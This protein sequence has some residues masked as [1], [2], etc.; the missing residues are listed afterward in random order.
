MKKKLLAM[1]LILTLS[2]LTYVTA[3]AEGGTNPPPPPDNT[4]N[5]T[6]INITPFCDLPPY[7]I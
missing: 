4:T 3:F 5:T 2:L 1:T 7:Y 6:Y